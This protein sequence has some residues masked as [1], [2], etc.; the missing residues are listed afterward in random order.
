[1]A[2]S[3]EDF[4][5]TFDYLGERGEDLAQLGILG[6]EGLIFF[7]LILGAASGLRGLGRAIGGS[8]RAV[9]A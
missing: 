3:R 4:V 1:M 9:A 6:I 5:P 7:G 2:F 8:R